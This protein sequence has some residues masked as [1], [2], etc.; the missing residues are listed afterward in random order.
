MGHSNATNVL[1]VTILGHRVGLE[2]LAVSV[3]SLGRVTTTVWGAAM[4]TTVP[5][6]TTLGHT[7]GHSNAH[8]CARVLPLNTAWGI[9]V[10]STV[11]RLLPL[12]TSV[13]A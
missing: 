13:G 5:L 12:D 3:G 1:L 8:Y 10:L 9:A 4:P 2:R 7:V 6:V 11:P